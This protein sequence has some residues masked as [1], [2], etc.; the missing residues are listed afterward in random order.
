M[1]QSDFSQRYKTSRCCCLVIFN[2]LS[3]SVWSVLIKVNKKNIQHQIQIKLVANKL[4]EYHLFM[5][6][7][8]VK[9][10]S[11]WYDFI[12]LKKSLLRLTLEKNAV[13]VAHWL[14][15]ACSFLSPL[16]YRLNLL[17]YLNIKIEACSIFYLPYP[18]F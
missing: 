14:I 11:N 16:L 18:Y 8:K 9:I 7:L 2:Y 4:K 17:T 12:A 1:D 15:E 13:T 3:W 5:Y 6:F 10:N